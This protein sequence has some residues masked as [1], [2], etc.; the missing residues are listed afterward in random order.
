MSQ[1]LHQ[2]KTLLL[3]ITVV[4]ALLVASPALQQILVIPQTY[5]ITELSILGQ[6]N[7]TT[8]PA[9]ITVGEIYRL[10]I[11]ITNQL[12]ACSYYSLEIKFRDQTQSAPDSFAH[13]A[14]NLPSIVSIP[15][16]VADKATYEILLDISFQY[17]VNTPNQLNVQEITVNC[18]PLTVNAVIDRDTT[19]N[20]FFGNLFFELCIYNSA[21]QAFEYHQRY[22]SLWLRMNV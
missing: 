6:Y 9:N 10:Y 18:V 13:T 11:D 20:G 5:H 15:F 19:R 14:S 2:Y 12:G 17:A 4:S 8:Y 3:A 7:N 22:I 16:F 1:K 21:T